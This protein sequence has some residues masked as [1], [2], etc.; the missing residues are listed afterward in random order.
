M[1]SEVVNAPNRMKRERE[2]HQERERD[3]QLELMLSKS[4][5]GVKLN[6]TPNLSVSFGS[7]FVGLGNAQQMAACGIEL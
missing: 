6:S 7:C 3:G 4:S 2:I 5:C 1:N